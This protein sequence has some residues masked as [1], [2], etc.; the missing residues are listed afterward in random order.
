MSWE[1]SAMKSGRSF[2]SI[3]IFRK[4]CARFWPLCGGFF[5]LFGTVYVLRFATGGR[6]WRLP[7]LRIFWILSME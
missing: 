3:P 1:V 4:N 7:R 6:A 2:C 5:L